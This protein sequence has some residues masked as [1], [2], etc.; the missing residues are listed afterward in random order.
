[1]LFY[2]AYGSN[3]HLKQMSKRCPLSKPYVKF[4]F[5]NW[6]LVFKGVADLQKNKNSFVNMGIYKITSE[7]ELSLDYYE[8][9]PFL[10]KKKFIYREIM[11]EKIRIM[12]YI[13][14]KKYEYSVPTVKYFNAIKKGYQNW[15]LEKNLLLESALHSIE[16]NTSNG[17]K[18]RNWKDK[19]F[20]DEKFIKKIMT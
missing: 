3:L 10:Y 4:H 6:Q 8:D 7:C 13:M 2:A 17:F 12:M 9:Y 14:K 20:I 15:G 11:G 19:N 16:N 18:S 5:H 1:M